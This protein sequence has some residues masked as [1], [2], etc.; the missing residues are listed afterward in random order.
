MAK[1]RLKDIDISAQVS[2]L[3]GER[4]RNLTNKEDAE[5][6]Q[7]KTERLRF[8]EKLAALAFRVK[9]KTKAQMDEL[10]MHFGVSRTHLLELAV[11]AVYRNV[12][13][14]PQHEVEASDIE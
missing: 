13:G 9:P 7:Q 3:G 5:Q 12:Y 8:K 10:A 11:D 4:L 2:V 1:N 6:E 14:N